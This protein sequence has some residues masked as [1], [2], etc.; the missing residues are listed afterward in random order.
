[1]GK[2]ASKLKRRIITWT[3]ILI[4]V[5]IALMGI[6]RLGL[7]YSSEI[8][9]ELV[10]RESKGYYELSFEKINFDLLNRAIKLQKVLL[11]PDTTRDF[12]DQ[13]IDNLYDLE[14]AEL[15]IDLQSIRSIYTDRKLVIEN[16]RIVD[17]LIHIIRKGDSGDESFSL[18][19]G[20][21]YKEISD[22]LKVLR[23]DVLAIEGADFRHSPSALALEN[24]DFFIGSLL[25]DSASRPD[26]RFYS[27]SIELEIRNQQFLLNDSIHQLS[28]DRLLLSTV[29]SVL[30]FDNLTLKPL[31]EDDRV[32]DEQDDK[33]IY[34]I[35]IPQL[36][37]K[38][39]DYFS[40]YRNNHLVM[41]EL[42]ITDSY[43]F[44]EEQKQATVNQ[45][46]KKDNSIIK[47]LMKVFDEVKIGRMRFINTHLDVKTNDDFN[48]NYQHVQTQRADIVLYD[49]YLDSTNYQVDYGKRYFDG[50]DVIIKDY[51]SHLPDSIHSVHFELLK[52]SSIDSS[53][54]FRNFKITHNA[55]ETGSDQYLFIDVPEVSVK[56]MNY[57]DV[58]T[59]KKLLIRELL[60]QDPNIAFESNQKQK[61]P[62]SFSP[63]SVFARIEKYFKVVGIGKFQMNQGSFSINQKID[64]KRA[65]LSIA[66]FRLD[67]QR[68]S[69]YDALHEVSLSMQNLALHDESVKLR[70]R[71][72]RLDHMANRLRLDGL[73]VNF[74]DQSK[75]VSGDV[76]NLSITGI[77]LDSISMGQYLAFDTIRLVHPQINFE[78]FKP[79]NQDSNDRD[80]GN[81]LI[82]IVNGQ[83][84]GKTH[85]GMELSL[86]H[87]NAQLAIGSQNDLHF[88]QAEE[89]NFTLP[90]LQNHLSINKLS[91]TPR[92]DV[93]ARDIEFKSIGDSL[94]HRVQLNGKIPIL[95]LHGLQQNAFWLDR[96]VKGDSLEIEANDLHLNLNKVTSNVAENRKNPL[97]LQFDKIKLEIDR[98][99]FSDQN[100]ESV[101][102]VVSPNVY[103]VL[104][105]FL[106][107]E[108]S[109]LSA[110]HLV[111]SDDVALRINNLRPILASGD[112]LAVRQLDFNKAK[113]LISISNLSYDQVNGAASTLLPS[114]R[115]IGLDLNAYVNGKDLKLDSIK[116]ESPDIVLVHD[117]TKEVKSSSASPFPE[118]L[119]VGY[120]SS[121]NTEIELRDSQNS[122]Y[123]IHQGT[124]QIRDFYSDGKIKW[125]RFFSYAQNASVSGKDFSMPLKHGYQLSIDQ[126]ALQHPQSS[127]TLD[128]FTLKS[129]F[130]PEQFSS[131]LTA[132]DNWFDV[133]VERIESQGV[134][135]DRALTEQE[136]HVEKV[137]FA[138][139]DALIYR[140]KSVPFLALHDRGLPQTMLKNI[141]ERIYIDTLQVLGDLVYQEKPVKNK[142]V[143]VLSFNNLNASLYNIT[144]VENEASKPMHL[145]SRGRLAD[146][147][148]FKVNV[149]FEMNDPEDQF[150]F[151]GEINDFYLVALNKML[152]PVA[153]INIKDGYA[154]QIDFH[155]VA[156]NELARGEMKLRYN[157]LKIQILKDE[158]HH[159]KGHSQGIKTFFANTFVVDDKNPSFIV[160][161]PGVIFQ[162]RDTSRAIFQYWAKSLLSG[163]VSSIGIN[164]S[165]KA[166]KKYGKEERD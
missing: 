11:K 111:Y 29:D 100:Q 133:E 42:S 143:G 22:Y 70:S 154:E 66:C 159:L 123:A 67:S 41:D 48:H 128:G 90:K 115:I 58:L 14:L 37:L 52:L 138:G 112:S 156:N 39:V 94:D 64:F 119:D 88:G 148:N 96:V 106:F 151:S 2:S 30:V 149:W 102:K 78:T 89:I 97:K 81:K 17:P 103:L 6:L 84:T 130:T 59:Q 35:S 105:G 150:T 32:F 122:T 125:D 80:F 25:I 54:F 12:S 79:G 127:L 163:A 1:M 82:H 4:V 18:Q 132:Q 40:A 9:H 108:K 86:H 7:L 26:Q 28:F 118:I 36:K 109:A 10:K 99:E 101:E 8:L 83:V 135:F 142:E 55:T 27:E 60:L 126:Y 162:P 157:D 76:S 134:D 85:E 50:F 77:N 141:N 71:Q 56:G 147:A 13:G 144:T 65:D 45:P 51:S 120:F 136:Y 95:T 16:I 46:L 74:R 145:Y 3:T 38:G 158:T 20:N 153:N 47:E 116:L 62:S 73:S 15:H 33:I 92:S 113:E 139:T 129:E 98:V 53:L 49:F 107:P 69:W 110:D 160:L 34:D 5:V 61:G 93:Y 21:V 57:M 19:T 44:L 140:D 137:L 91:L 31:S 114:T 165:K 104:E 87:L 68:H 43:L 131:T 24:I 117:T 121:T 161:K 72:L 164:K 124:I 155:F 146:T 75:A 152:K 63:D 166:E 23:I